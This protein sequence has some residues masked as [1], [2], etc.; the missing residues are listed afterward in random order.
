LASSFSRRR[1]T[2]RRNQAR[3][4]FFFATS[5]LCAGCLK[6]TPQVVRIATELD[7][8]K[9]LSQGGDEDDPDNWQGLCHDCHAEKSAL[10]AGKTPP[11][12][13]GFDADGNP[14][15]SNHPWNKPRRGGV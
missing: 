11:S 5:P 7:H 3:R 12:T 10:E 6:K 15:G 8:I 2:G 13:R 4:R 14:T 1:I 9:P